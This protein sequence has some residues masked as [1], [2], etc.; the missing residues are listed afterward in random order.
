MRQNRN[1]PSLLLIK[2]VECG[3]LP[4]VFSFLFFNKSTG[5]ETGQ[6][7]EKKIGYLRRIEFI[8]DYFR[9]DDEHD[10]NTDVDH[11]S[12]S[13]TKSAN[14]NCRIKKQQQNI[15]QK[16]EWHTGQERLR[17]V[18]DV[19]YNDLNH[20]HYLQLLGRELTVVGKPQQEYV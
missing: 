10:K 9:D 4:E 18:N 14:R 5:Y 17:K 2:Q 15:G 12:V 8:L 3:E 11:Q 7:V 6:Q 19:R 13:K 16:E 1:Y 20:D